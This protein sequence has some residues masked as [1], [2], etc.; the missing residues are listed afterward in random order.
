MIVVSNETEL[1]ATAINKL[2]QAMDEAYDGMKLFRN[3][4]EADKMR[5][6]LLTPF[7]QV[8][9]RVKALLMES[10]SAKIEQRQIDEI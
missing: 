6:E 5:E 8:R 4:I 9:D 2:E 10:V 3:E 7:M 1:F